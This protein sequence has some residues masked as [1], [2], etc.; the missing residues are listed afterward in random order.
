MVLADHDKYWVVGQ[1]HK[2]DQL[3]YIPIV[4]ANHTK[5]GVVSW[6]HKCGQIYYV[7][8]VLANHNKYGIISWYHRCDLLCYILIVLRLGLIS[9]SR[10]YLFRVSISSL[11]PCVLPARLFRFYRT[12]F[13]LSHYLDT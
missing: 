11:L 7:L 4:L 2:C 9:V 1:Y 8:M 3:Y 10:A 12:Y 13:G 6:Y 5:Y